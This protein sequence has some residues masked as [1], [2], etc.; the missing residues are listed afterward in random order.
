MR[1][2]IQN[3]VQQLLVPVRYQVKVK[4]EALLFCPNMTDTSLIELNGEKV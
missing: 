1:I 2:A 4:A 3:G